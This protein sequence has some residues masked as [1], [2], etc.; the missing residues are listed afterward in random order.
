MTATT[1]VTPKKAAPRTRRRTELFMPGPAWWNAGRESRMSE[2]RL[3]MAS[4]NGEPSAASEAVDGDPQLASRQRLAHCDSVAAW[5]TAART[6]LP[7]FWARL[8]RSDWQLAALRSAASGAGR[9][10]FG[11]AGERGQIDQLRPIAGF[12]HQVADQLDRAKLGIGDVQARRVA[13]EVVGRA[14][15][16]W[17][18]RRPAAPPRETTSSFQRPLRKAPTSLIGLIGTSTSPLG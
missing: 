2:D 14:G 6:T 10:S 15:A 7:A 3:P 13:Q 5:S 1:Q 9:H 17:P 4:A 8:R 18:S 11:P 16:R 12:G